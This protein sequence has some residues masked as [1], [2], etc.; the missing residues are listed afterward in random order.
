MHTDP[1]R[2]CAVVFMTALSGD[3]THT[4]THTQSA[5]ICIHTTHKS[6]ERQSQPKH[7]DLMIEKM[8]S[9]MQTSA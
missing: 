6:T 7:Q 3:N 4:R 2:P 8:C 9:Y 1:K 5:F